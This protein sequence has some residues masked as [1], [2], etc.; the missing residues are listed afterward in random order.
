MHH[1]NPESL[2]WTYD[3]HLLASR[4]SLRE[5]AAFADLAVARRMSAVCAD[6]LSRARRWFGTVVPG[7][8]MATLHASGHREPSAAYLRPGRQWRDELISSIRGLPR[9]RDRLRLLR[10]V[11]LPTPTYMLTSYGLRPS[12]WS[13]ALLPALYLHRLSIGGWKAVAGQK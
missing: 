5:F 11:A 9:W 8:V 4:L 1:R 2:I 7:A 13:A 3:V 10:E 12:S 6:Q